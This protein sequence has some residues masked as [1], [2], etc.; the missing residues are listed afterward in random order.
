MSQDYKENFNT[1][2]LN[3]A[4]DASG[5]FGKV[6][7]ALKTSFSGATAPTPAQGRE[8]FQY[9]L[10]TSA[11]PTYVLKIRNAAD[12]DWS[13]VWTWNGVDSPKSE[14]NPRVNAITNGDFSLW[15]RGDGFS[16]V[17]SSC[18]YTAD[19]WLVCGNSGGV[20]D[21][22]RNTFAAGQTDVPNNPNY[23]FRLNQT[24]A[25]AGS[26]T[27]STKI[28]N[29]RSFSGETVTLS[30]W[31]RSDDIADIFTPTL[32]QVFGTGGSSTV[33]TVLST[34]NADSV[35]VW[36]QKTLTFQVPSISG[37][38]V[39][40]EGTHY[41]KLEIAGPAATVYSFEIANV[42][43][44]RG[45]FATRFERVDPDQ[46]ELLNGHPD[47]FSETWDLLQTTFPGINGNRSALNYAKGGRKNLLINGDTRIWQRGTS[48]GPSGTS[49]YS[50]DRWIMN[51]KAGGS[52]T[53]SQQTFTAG[54]TDVPTDSPYYLRL[55]EANAGGT[56]SSVEQ[57]VQNVRFFSQKTFTLSYWIKSDSSADHF[58]NVKQ[59]FGTGGSTQVDVAAG[60]VSINSTG[61][62]QYFETTFTTP[63]V[64]GKTIT[65]DNYFR[66]IL[67]GPTGI[68]HNT[69]ICNVQLEVGTKATTFQRENEVDVYNEC[70]KYYIELPSGNIFLN[71]DG[72]TAHVNTVSH[73]IEFP[74]VM[75]AIPAITLGSTQFLSGIA[76]TSITRYGFAITATATDASNGAR[77]F[78]YIADAEV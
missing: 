61:V 9:W 59:F 75:R 10:D 4:F 25:G 63:D 7:N 17:P 39:G 21:V 14:V 34:F 37:K 33:D 42:Q 52:S 50:A 23:F 32:S 35:S 73:H 27:I 68:A 30:F 12:T 13:V 66:V 22:S 5:E 64:T 78:S 8:P 60:V 72:T 47:E 70:I 38:T 57:R 55:N 77:L 28:D 31:M 43:L 65:A 36:E 40:T 1:D 54:Q 15:R 45:E 58:F 56:E 2:T 41:L 74:V 16:S 71:S 18:Q 20:S 6:V 29:V 76:S 48:I 24:G 44:E 51:P 53:V 62:W 49:Q 46:A 67:E 11:A 26:A 3:N 19:G 69:D